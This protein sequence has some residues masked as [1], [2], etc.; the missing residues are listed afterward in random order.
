MLEQ[1]NK[2]ILVLIVYIIL[3][4]IIVFLK[5]DIAFNN[6]KD[7]LRY[8]GVGYKNTTILPLWLISVLVAIISYF[9][10]LYML[11][12]RYNCIFINV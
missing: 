1:V 5:P 8:F 3:Y 2:L 6:N 12:I 9:F 4:T 10:V 7:C 11:H